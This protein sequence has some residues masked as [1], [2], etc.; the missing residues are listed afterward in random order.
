MHGATIKINNIGMFLVPQ[1]KPTACVC[2][3]L[4]QHSFSVLA[5]V[6]LHNVRN[7]VL[8]QSVVLLSVQYVQLSP[9]HHT[10]HVLRLTAAKTDYL[11]RIFRFTR[12]VLLISSHA[13]FSRF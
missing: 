1:M 13:P 2:L 8:E 12:T 6:T 11:V 7:F 9:Q 10:I 3:W 4:V 5:L